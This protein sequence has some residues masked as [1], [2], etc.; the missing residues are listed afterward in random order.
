MLRLILVAF[1]Y[2][3]AG[4]VGQATI[5][6]RSNN[7]G[8][9]WPAFGVALAAIILYGY[10]IWPGV[11][12]AAFLVAYLSPVGPLTA[13]GQASGATL[14]AL[15]GAFL[16]RRIGFHPRMARL[17]DAVWLITVG[18]F[19]GALVSSSIGTVTL[20]LAHI[21]A[22]S[23]LASAWLVYWMGDNTGVL[24]VTPLLLTGRAFSRIRGGRTLSEFALLILLLSAISLL[25]F[26]ER[27]LLPVSL[28]FLA[29]AVLPFVMW[30]ATRMGTAATSLCVLIVAGVATVETALG[31][32][33][34]ASATPFMNAV[35]LDIF[36]AVVSV[37]GLTLAG[38][39]TEREELE[40]VRERLAREEASTAVRLRLASIMESSD[41]AIVGANIDGAITD[42][43]KGAELLFGYRNS[44]IFGRPLTVLLAPQSPEGLRGVFEDLSRMAALNRYD[45]VCQRKD[46]REFEAAV[47]V[48]P[49][50]DTAGRICGGSVSVRDITLRKLQE[51][52][53]RESESRFRLVADTAPV[54]IWMS[55]PD[56][57][58]TYFNKPWLDFVGR[59]LES[60]LGSGWASGV[61]RDDLEHCL[62]TYAHCFDR[63]E[64]L[65][66]EYRLRRLDGEYRWILDF[67]VPRFNQDGSFAGY[68]GSCLDITESKLAREAMSTVS[69]RLIEAQENERTRIARELHDDINQ[70]LSLLAV[71]LEQSLHAGTDSSKTML[72][73]AFDRVC[74]ITTDIQALSH[75]LHSSKLEHLGLVPALKSFCREF[76]Q[77]QKLT[78]DFTHCEVDFTV[79]PEV[80]LTFFRILQE[81]LH[82]AV[83]HSQ[84]RHFHVTLGCNEE[85]IYLRVADSGVGFDPE[86]EEQQRGLGL[87][88]MKERAKLAEG[89]VTIDSKPGQGTTVYVRVPLSTAR[90]SKS[91]ARL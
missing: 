84:I 44:E 7:I 2:W 33:P 13:L 16:L 21:T 68:I 18:A 26:A 74:E 3:V 78:V 10:R 35:M 6:I 8:P 73:T 76:A 87:V 71:E 36:F 55:G 89:T 15:T 49:I 54:L 30:S 1:V 58:R 19:V 51:A 40:R 62:S 66:M 29:F 81:A 38:A 67:G 75:D 64:T 12:G 61:H 83:K 56:K 85:D 86:K 23:G 60:E 20:Y 37:T 28:N 46:H 22:Y 53:L 80:S 82:N 57:Q 32:G 17:R 25:I 47:R 43:N 72:Q 69:R 34:F 59:P 45:S 88:S 70:R 24:L 63:R 11:A 9:V 5:H 79:S 50:L 39:I 65:R 4:V 52:I 42:W 90:K 41:D 27:P 91:E 77:Q 14:G 31:F 48:S